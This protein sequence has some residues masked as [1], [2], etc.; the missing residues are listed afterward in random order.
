MHAHLSCPSLKMPFRQMVSFYFT[1]FLAVKS[2]HLSGT[3]IPL[4]RRKKD[5]A[6]CTTGSLPAL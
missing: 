6:G 2:K 5:C 3:L 4:R 1:Y